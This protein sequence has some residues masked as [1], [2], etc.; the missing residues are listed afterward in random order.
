MTI[1]KAILAKQR[2]LKISTKAKLKKIG[3]SL[4]T[5]YNMLASTPGH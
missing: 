3:V 4:S 5:L 1:A 2:T